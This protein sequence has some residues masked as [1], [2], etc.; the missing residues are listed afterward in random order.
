VLQNGQRKERR[1]PSIPRSDG[2]FHLLRK[3]TAVVLSASSKIGRNPELLHA[4]AGDEMVMLSVEAGNYYGLDPIGRRIWDLLDE[5]ARVS[6][7]CARL[8]AEFQVEPEDCEADVLSFLRE[9]A[10]RRIVNVLA[11]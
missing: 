2:R 11:D 10:E 8:T 7:I 9:L 1:A 4:A 5:P 3:S 6:D